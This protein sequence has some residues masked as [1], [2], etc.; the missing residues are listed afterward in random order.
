MR[1]TGTSPETFGF[2]LAIGE[3]SVAELVGLSARTVAFLDALVA[4]AVRSLA[5]ASALAAAPGPH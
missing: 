3:T 5:S 1:L 2:A 4:A